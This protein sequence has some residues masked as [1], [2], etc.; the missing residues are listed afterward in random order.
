MKKIL[1]TVIIPF[2]VF[3]IAGCLSKPGSL[4]K[5][6][7]SLKLKITLAES[8]SRISAQAF[9]KDVRQLKINLIKDKINNEYLKSFSLETNE[10]TIQRIY[11]GEWTVN[12][13]GLDE[14]EDAIFFGSVKV[15]IEPG[16]TA[17]ASPELRPGPGFIDISINGTAFPGFGTTITK[18]TFYVYLDPTSNDHDDFELTMEGDYFRRTITLPEGTYQ[19]NLAVPNRSTGSYIS[20]YFTINIL[21]GKTVKYLIAP[22][23]SVALTGTIDSSPTT[24][25]N[26][27]AT[28]DEN[29]ATVNLEWD[30]VSDSDLAGYNLYRTDNFGRFKRL[31]NLSAAARSYSDDVS[32]ITAG[33][34]GYAVGSFDLG[35][36]E[37]LWSAPVYITK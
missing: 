27:K 23:G 13:Y 21:A 37:S 9:A 12:I 2:A 36:N 3:L 32:A 6:F 7:G 26:F 24:P 17:T 16:K 10:I 30:P 33:E 20:P 19:A 18:A 29:G 31:N 15:L 25:Q 1:I 35:G 28:Y 34:I 14:E 4:E 8:S 22:D 11:P 5:S